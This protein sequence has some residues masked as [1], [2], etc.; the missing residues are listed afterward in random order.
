MS[1]G[2]C[3]KRRGDMGGGGGGG[4]G[5]GV[6]RRKEETQEIYGGHRHD[7]SIE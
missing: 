2:K 5:G 7:T 6:G 4:G 1:E 3:R